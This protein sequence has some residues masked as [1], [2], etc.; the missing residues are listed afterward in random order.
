MN[1]TTLSRLSLL[2]L[3]LSATACAGGGLGDLGEILTGGPAA[4]GSGAGAGTV[5][6]EVQEV[7]EQQEQIIV[8]TQEGQQ[9]PILYDQN[10]Q[11]VYQGEQYPVRALETGDLVDMRV[12]EVQQGY[13][14]D[15]IEVREPVQERQGGYRDSPA[16]DVYRVEGTIG[17]I[18]AGRS[19][20]TLQM[21][22]GGTLPVHLPSDA[23]AADRDRLRQYQPG[24]YVRVE[25]R[26]I[27][28]QTA[29]LVRWGWER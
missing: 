8:R 20:F 4:P 12:R 25:V 9:G 22:Q 27:D 5:T 3:A 1:T 29:E 7:R 21:T 28:E 11:V 2:T 18:D 15:L 24:D 6:V 19:M 23:S 13:Y 10:T 17:D 16:P 26:P 14:T